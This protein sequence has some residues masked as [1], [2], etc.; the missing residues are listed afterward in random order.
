MRSD[1]DPN[2]FARVYDKPPWLLHF[3]FSNERY[4]YR[5]ALV[6]KIAVGDIKPRTKQKANELNLSHEEIWQTYGKHKD[7]L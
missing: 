3:Q 7:T 6:E 4:V 2:N 5:Y 1:F